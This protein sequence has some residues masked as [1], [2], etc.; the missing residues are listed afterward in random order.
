MIAD[1]K[2]QLAY[3][4][5]ETRSRQ[6][7]AAES[8]IADLDAS[9]NYPHDFVVYRVTGFRP[10]SA[11]EPVT[12]VGEALQADLATLV[13]HLSDELTL[14]E[15]DRPGGAIPLEEL[16]QR[17]NV[18]TKTIQRYRRQGLMCHTITFADG[19]RRLGCFARE[20]E[21][22]ER[23][24]AQQVS[25]AG[26]YSRLSREARAEIV[27]NAA[28]LNRA[29]EASLNRVAERLAPSVQR[30]RETVRGVLRRHDESSS[31][32]IFARRPPMDA[33]SR[34]FIVRCA[35]RGLPLAEIAD[36]LQRRPAAIHRIVL[37]ERLKELRSLQLQ[38]IELPTFK[39]EGADQVILAPSPVSAP[40]MPWPAIPVAVE[41]VATL[42]SS[43]PITAGDEQALLAAYNFL[44]RRA[45]QR[46]LTTTAR[47]RAGDLDAAE[48]DLRWA[49]LLKQRLVWSMMVL[50]LRRVEL[51]FGRRVAELR[52]DD[53]RRVLSIGFEATSGAVEVY[54]PTKQPRLDR[55]W[56]SE[57]DR[58]LEPLLAAK[59]PTRAASRV[60]ASPTQSV[61]P[62]DRIAP[63]QG[64]LGPRNVWR[65]WRASLP[66]P[67]REL[68]ERRFGWSDA[69]P[70]TLAA[71]SAALS[72]PLVRVTED[73][74]A[75]QRAVR[76]V[77]GR[78]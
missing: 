75:A 36:R 55:W 64:A 11:E 39:L 23:L 28:E 53:S 49:A 68:L 30:A 46:V 34:R 76:A 3:A 4:P 19:E 35:A 12:L 40:T 2:R 48:T 6:M 8:L 43:R 41:I 62:M 59:A 31:E 42:A 14:R 27:A 66:M 44:K 50:V 18:S 25:A 56:T 51:N 26:S 57:L 45:A 1:L 10:E 7:L 20:V 60:T 33:R 69:P 21:R 72:R 67:Q 54:D 37:L 38:W 61:D 9:R 47:P 32:P 58:A 70:Q 13:Q 71:M 65:A 77:P 17:W 29:G 73:V 16:A 52:S 74:T 15:S 78:D 24:R 63:W 5:E 22:F